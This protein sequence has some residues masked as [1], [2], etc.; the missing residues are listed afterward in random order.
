MRRRMK[1][2]HKWSGHLK[3]INHH[4]WLVFVHCC[5]AG[6][7]RQGI[8]HDLSKYHPVEF[9]L[10]VRYYQGDRSPHHAERE[11][12]GKSLAW[13]HHKGRNKH[14]L[15]YWIDYS[16]QN[17]QNLQGMEM[18][19]RYV[20]EMFCDRVAASK[21]YY[22]DKYHDGVAYAYYMHSKDHYLL[23]PKTRA[24]LERLL[25]LLKNKGEDAAFRYIRKYLLS[26]A[27]KEIRR[28]I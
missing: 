12:M 19:V 20:I 5:K 24:L 15:E 2:Q 26:I 9:L 4:K 1:G 18:P 22:K 10:G 16:V 14:H 23:H 21:N 13:L 25:I 27:K 28:G 6:I 8:M 3:T 7:Y 17:G 11:A